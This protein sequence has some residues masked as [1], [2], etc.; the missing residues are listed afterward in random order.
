[1]IQREGLE[2]PTWGNGKTA[3]KLIRNGELEL[4]RKVS[5]IIA[6]MSF[7]WI[8][9]DDDAGPNS[10]RGYIERNA[11]ALLSNYAK[12]R[13][14]P[15]SNDWLGHCS[16]KERVKNSGLWNQNHVDEVC[17]STFLDTLDELVRRVRDVT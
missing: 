3:E 2:F 6:D 5:R 15:P 14:D 9:I 4:E 13:L 12:A 1:L 7:L 10:L 11:I 16:D 8:R 17:D